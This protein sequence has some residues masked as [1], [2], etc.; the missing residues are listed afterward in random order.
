MFLQ[1]RFFCVIS[2]RIRHTS[3]SAAA[4]LWPLVSAAWVLPGV[5]HQEGLRGD[6][7]EHLPPQPRLR[8]HVLTREAP[9]SD[10]IEGG[11]EVS[12]GAELGFWC[13]ARLHVNLL[14]FVWMRET[15]RRSRMISSGGGGEK[16][17]ESMRERGR[18]KRP[19]QTQRLEKIYRECSFVF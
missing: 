17:D 16:I 12:R 4:D 9:E 15:R 2:G 6:R 10:R 1:P 7:A 8:S 3:S 19:D 5:P 13:A 18:E 14:S 11:G